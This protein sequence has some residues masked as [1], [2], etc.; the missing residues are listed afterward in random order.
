MT[1]KILVGTR[2]GLFV[3]ERNPS[4]NGGWRLKDP[5]FL[6]DPVSMV[7]PDED[8]GWL[9]AL[10]LGHFGVKLHRSQDY[11][12]S[13][14]ECTSPSFPNNRDS[15]ENRSSHSVN[16]V[17]ALESGEEGLLWAGTIPAALF[18]STDQGK[19]WQLNQALWSRP[20]RTEWFGGGFDEPGIHS[21]C[22]DP[23]DRNSL[24]VGISCGGVWYSSDRGGSWQLRASGM[25]AEYMP[26]ERT[27]DPNIQDP[28]CLVQ[29]TGAPDNF[30]AQHHNGVFRSSDTCRSWQEIETAQPSRFGFAAVVH[31]GDPETAWFVP[32]VKDECRV[33]VDGRLVVSRTRDGG[34][35][36]ETL[37]QGLPEE[38]SYDLVYRHAMDID[39]SGETL[40]VG[41]TTGSLWIS[42]NQGDL[43]NC[44]SNHLPPIYCVRFVP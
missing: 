18:E 15:E 34:Q 21:I 37:S 32:A 9:A 17:W 13:W 1:A 16:Q 35:T 36:F 39:L 22:V 26:P 24:A 42:E 38:R 6:G 41:S 12:K 8:S 30:W 14:E 2:K 11:G 5:H 3:L 23:R 29:C 20:E 25:R 7:L 33:P 44:I 28:H 27:M 19:T 4:A 10:N 31:P 40:A 43:W